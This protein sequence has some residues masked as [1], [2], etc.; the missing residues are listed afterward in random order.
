MEKKIFICEYCGNTA[1]SEKQL[2]KE[3]WLQIHGG[4]MRGISIWLDKPR[5]TKKGVSSSFMLTIGY[6]DRE[7]HF[8]SIKCLVKLL[9][10][11]K[12]I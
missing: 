11:K 9:K 3:N 2:R 7:Y 6:Q 12:S 10:G 5:E 4:I 1:E 8:C